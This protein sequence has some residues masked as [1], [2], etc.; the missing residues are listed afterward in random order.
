MLLVTGEVVFCYVM[1]YAI[2]IWLKKE[3]VE[4]FDA[5]EFVYLH[6]HGDECFSHKLQK[7]SLIDYLDIVYFETETIFR[8]L[9][10]NGEIIFKSDP[11]ISLAKE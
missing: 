7:S 3:N 11:E 8:S 1:C 6:L 9:V 2:I 5:A 4:D 10:E